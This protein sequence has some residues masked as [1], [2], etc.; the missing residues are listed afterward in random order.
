MTN[1]NQPSPDESANNSDDD[2]L[3]ELQSI[4]DTSQTTRNQ[5]KYLEEDA[6]YELKHQMNMQILIDELYDDN[7]ELSGL[8]TSTLET[9]QAE[10]VSTNDTMSTLIK[11]YDTIV[12]QYGKDS[13]EAYLLLAIYDTFRIV[14]SVA[15]TMTS[16]VA[17]ESKK[18]LKAKVL[19][20]NKDALPDNSQQSLYELINTH[21]E[22][23]DDLDIN[24]PAEVMEY[25][26]EEQADRELSDEMMA[27]GRKA[28]LLLEKAFQERSWNY[29]DDP[30]Y[31]DLI[32]S[33]RM[34]IVFGGRS[35]IDQENLAALKISEDAIEEI[36]AI[37]ESKL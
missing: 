30:A 34:C 21:V 33:L 2:I 20:L 1:P 19:D 17:V 31:K 13:A 4:I 24:N 32:F 3:L 8:L 6:E 37:V 5:I 10:G 12:L 18:E 27:K 14:E 29:P 22:S 11:M 28:T 15:D 7:E 16:G 26:L 35:F 25:H 36:I 9:M 23:Y